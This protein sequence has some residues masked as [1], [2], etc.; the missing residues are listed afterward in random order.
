MSFFEI[1]CLTG[2]I[3]GIIF[4]LC[5]SLTVKEKIFTIHNLLWLSCFVVFGFIPIT[6][7]IM[8]IVSIIICVCF[9]FIIGIFVK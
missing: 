7:M 5:V 8:I 4:I 1:W 2:L 3:T 9:N 6:V